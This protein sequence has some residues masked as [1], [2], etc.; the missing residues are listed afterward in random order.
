MYIYTF[1]HLGNFDLR[2]PDNPSV[3][4][5]IPYIPP[6]DTFLLSMWIKIDTSRGKDAT[7]FELDSGRG[8]V[9]KLK[10]P[11]LLND[12]EFFFNCYNSSIS[13]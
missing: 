12:F 3:T 13:L 1:V 10:R 7:I 11:G 8:T 2:F 5:D 4:I 6:L 9:L